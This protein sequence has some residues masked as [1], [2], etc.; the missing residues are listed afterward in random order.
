MGCGGNVTMSSSRP[1]SLRG[2]REWMKQLP[3]QGMDSVDC[4]SILIEGPQVMA[5]EAAV[6]EAQVRVNLLKQCTCT[7]CE[8]V[9]G[10]EQ[11]TCWCRL[12]YVH[13]T[14]VRECFFKNKG[15]LAS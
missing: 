7:V 13:N 1:E 14:L 11:C 8:L 4:G 2:V 6:R 3:S 10:G 15:Q 12:R 5:I 9:V